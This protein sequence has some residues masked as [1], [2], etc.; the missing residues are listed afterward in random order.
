MYQYSTVYFAKVIEPYVRA[1]LHYVNY[2]AAFLYNP[3]LEQLLPQC[4][5]F[6]KAGLHYGNYRS[7]LVHFEEQKIIFYIFIQP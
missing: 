2:R 3:R 4:K 1:D 7:K 6:F 5:H